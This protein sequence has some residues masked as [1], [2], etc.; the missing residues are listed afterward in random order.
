M[1]A[2]VAGQL[3]GYGAS[4]TAAPQPSISNVSSAGSVPKEGMLGSSSSPIHMV[5]S[6]GGFKQQ[7]W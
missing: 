4:F 3:H 5:T 1:K 6:E 7:F 2:R